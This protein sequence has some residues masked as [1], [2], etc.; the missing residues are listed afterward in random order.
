MGRMAQ[1]MLRQQLPISIDVPLCGSR[2]QQQ[3]EETLGKSLNH[4]MIYAVSSLVLSG[5]APA[6]GMSSAIRRDNFFHAL[7]MDSDARS[8]PFLFLVTPVEG[9]SKRGR[10]AVCSSPACA[11]RRCA[12][13]LALFQAS[14]GGLMSLAGTFDSLPHTLIVLV[15]SFLPFQSL[16][17]FG[18]VREVASAIILTHRFQSCKTIYL[19]SR[20]PELWS[21]LLVQHFVDKMP[22]RVLPPLLPWVSLSSIPPLIASVFL[23]L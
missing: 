3:E 9:P 2:E 15:M 20:A 18:K 23:P 6:P 21:R 8:R 22:K 1:L 19:C 16:V 14:S 12:K 4:V 5:S 10:T 13:S 7:G 17:A 11:R